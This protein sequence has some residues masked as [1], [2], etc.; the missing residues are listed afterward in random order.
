MW[1]VW[2]GR[3]RLSPEMR[4][5][6]PVRRLFQGLEIQHRTGLH[7]DGRVDAVLRLYMERVP[8]S[9]T[10]TRGFCMDTCARV[11]HAAGPGFLLS[12]EGFLLGISQSCA[13]GCVCTRVTSVIVRA[14]VGHG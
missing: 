11:F 6:I 9:G 14:N 1:R 2:H 12:V 8:A 10:C 4:R 5:F 13:C 7:G 3:W